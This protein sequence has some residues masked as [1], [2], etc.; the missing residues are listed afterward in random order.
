MF[1]MAFAI[2]APALVV[3]GFAERMRFAQPYHAHQPAVA[4]GALRVPLC[5]WIW[6]KS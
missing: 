5:H 3:G 4:A 1:Q 2:I 6:G